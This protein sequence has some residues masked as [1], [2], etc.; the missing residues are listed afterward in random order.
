MLT[1]TFLE[2]CGMSR[3][4]GYLTFKSV[5]GKCI[6]QQYKN[7]NLKVSPIWW[8]KRELIWL[9]GFA[10]YDWLLQWF[11]VSFLV[12]IDNKSKP[13][14]VAM[15]SIEVAVI[16]SVTKKKDDLWLSPTKKILKHNL[17]KI[18]MRFFHFSLPG[19]DRFVKCK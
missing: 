5:T 14:N 16:Q 15:T 7:N 10:K 8:Y 12:I 3:R 18:C 4:H 17:L 13:N 6:F 11:Q 2:R 9:N 1:N 19:Y